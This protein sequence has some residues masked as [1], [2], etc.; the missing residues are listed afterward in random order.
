MAPVERQPP[1]TRPQ[2]AL[3]AFGRTI[4]SSVFVVTA[5]DADGEPNGATISASVSLSLDPPLVLIC[6]AHA[7]D[8]LAAIR[9]TG[10]FRL[11]VLAAGQDA[12]S[13]A[14]AGRRREA[15]SAHLDGV[16]QNGAPALRNALAAARCRVASEFSAGDHAIVVGALEDVSVTAAA[17]LIYHCGGYAALAA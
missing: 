7:S 11:H 17:P 14:F 6:L 16:D 2:D 4:A 12:V 3:K 15:Y 1:Q 13:Q 9:Q 5:S 10:C 8:T